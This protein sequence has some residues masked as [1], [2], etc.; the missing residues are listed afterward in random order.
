MSEKSSLA[1]GRPARKCRK[2]TYTS[3]LYKKHKAKEKESQVRAILKKNHADRST[4]E[5]QIIKQN[6]KVV[7]ILEKRVQLRELNRQK[8]QEVEDSVGELEIKVAELAE[9]VQRAEN[10]VIYTGAGISTAASI[11]DY[12]GPNGVWTLLQQGK[13]SE[14]QNSSL[15]DAE[16]TLTH[17]ALARLVE[18]GMV[19]HIVSQNCDGLHFRSGVPPDRLSELHGNMYIE[20]C[21]ECEPERQYVRLFDVTEQTSLR[22]HK[23]SR[24][25]H[26]CKEPLRDTIVHFGEKGV[27]DKPLNWSGAM[28]AA[29]DADAILCLGSSLKVLRRY[30][31]L[32]STDRPKSQRPKLFIV[33]LQWTPKDSQASLK[34]HGRCDDVMALLMKHLNLSIPLYTRKSDPIFKMAA[35]IKPHEEGSY[36]TRSLLDTRLNSESLNL[37]VNSVIK[38]EQDNSANNLASSALSQKPKSDCASE[39]NYNDSEDTEDYEMEIPVALPSLE[40]GV[41]GEGNMPGWFGKGCR[42]KVVRKVGKKRRRSRVSSVEIGT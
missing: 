15:V 7:K 5:E 24:E 4:E 2:A 34:I 37:N 21:T 29:E 1:I 42:K 36:L 20:V 18:E 40:G 17:M 13:G 35:P 38:T 14:L 22:R 33:N 23:T 19:K 11:P 27:I 30:Q 32:W 3:V 25:C 39:G 9:E 16:P 6:K 41:E 28:D 10:L 8:S 12:R 26:K 31:C